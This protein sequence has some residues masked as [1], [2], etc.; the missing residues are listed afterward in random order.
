MVFGYSGLN[1]D[2]L[3]TW[4]RELGLE[5]YGAVLADND[6]D[7]NALRLL[8][9]A[10]LVSLGVSLGHRRVLLKAIAELNASASPASSPPSA[11][12]GPFEKS[13]DQSATTAEGERR[14]LTVL[15]C[16]M[17]GFTELANRVD[18][19]YCS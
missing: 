3:L 18:P 12:Q 11:E 16:D 19:K 10:D 9:D 4:L 13:S 17:V 1:M 14:Q 15:F 6:V 8:T 7:L 5:R 2:A